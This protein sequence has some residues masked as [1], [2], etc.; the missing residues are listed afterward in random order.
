M[1]FLYYCDEFDVVA[2][3]IKNDKS[4][5][6]LGAWLSLWNSALCC[7]AARRRICAW[8]SCVRVLSC[9][10][11]PRPVSPACPGSRNHG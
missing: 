4:S 9:Q 7:R 6:E 1:T 5:G 11:R 10:Q 8:S 3:R 2:K